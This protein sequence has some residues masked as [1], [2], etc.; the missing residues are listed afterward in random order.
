LTTEGE[1]S[2]KED[3]GL[4]WPLK[5]GGALRKE[6]GLVKEKEGSVDI[7]KG[8]LKI[9]RPYSGPDE[10]FSRRKK[11]V[12]EKRGCT[13]SSQGGGEEENDA[14]E[15]RKKNNQRGLQQGRAV[16]LWGGRERLL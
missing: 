1:G 2:G 10:G 3:G 11:R 12:L 16:R 9:G 7:K 5:E 6:I 4:V 14:R 15:K 8:S 13:V